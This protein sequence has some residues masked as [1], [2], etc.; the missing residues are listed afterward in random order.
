[1]DGSDDTGLVWGFDELG[2][3]LRKRNAMELFSIDDIM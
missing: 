1:M 2:V 3:D